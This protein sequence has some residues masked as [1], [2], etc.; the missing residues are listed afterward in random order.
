[1]GGPDTKCAEC[2]VRANGAGT[3]A[4]RSEGLFVQRPECAGDGLG[5]GVP[6]VISGETE[7]SPAERSAPQ[8]PLLLGSITHLFRVQWDEAYGSNS[9]NS[10]PQRS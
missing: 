9:Q 7:C 4:A 5:L 3:Y 10:I 1:M 6:D 8:S 2:P